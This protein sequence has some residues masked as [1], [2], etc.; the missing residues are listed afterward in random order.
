[1]LPLILMA[2]GTAM[3]IAG[4]YA[5]NID[6]ARM[7]TLNAE[8]FREQAN[9]ARMANLN[10]LRMSAAE[11][12]YRRGQLIG[13]FAGQG[14]DVSKGSALGIITEEVVRGQEELTALKTKGDLDVKLARLRGFSAQNTA[15]T[16]GSTMYNATQAGTTLLTAYGQSEGFGSWERNP[17]AG[18]TVPKYGG[19][20]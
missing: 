10:E 7:E 11:H 9:Q 4:D 17:A 1:M 8:F 12:S 13:A 16:M 14:L 2:V 6:R 5:S 20:S 15:D 19:A 18:A 3:K